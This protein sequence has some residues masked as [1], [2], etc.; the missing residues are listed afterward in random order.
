MSVPYGVIA[1]CIKHGTV[2]PFLGAGA[3]FAGAPPESALPIG[4][5]L[6]NRLIQMSGA[7]YPGSGSDP[8]TKI[9]QYLEETPADRTFLLRGIHSIF[10]QHVP[11]GYRCSVSDFLSNL[12]SE[13][14]P[15]LIV[16]TNYDVVLEWTF[17][18]KI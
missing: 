12:P 3:S 13:L 2:V 1:D 7:E 5:G 10:Y 6:A 15:K 17:E 18:G 9:T 8:L 16:T 14:I 4:T 11:D